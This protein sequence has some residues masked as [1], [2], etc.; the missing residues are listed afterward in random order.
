MPA[1][2]TDILRPDTRQAADHSAACFFA[3]AG[4]CRNLVSR[5]FGPAA[6]HGRRTIDVRHTDP[7][8]YPDSFTP[9]F[10]GL[11]FSID[12]S[13]QLG[14]VWRNGR[15]KT[16]PIRLLSGE[17]SGTGSILS[18]VGFDRF[19]F[20]C[21][22][23]QSALWNMRRAVAPFD[24]WEAEME[25]LLQEG[26]KASLARWGEIQE[27]YAAA[28]GYSINELPGKETARLWLDPDLLSR[29]LCSF[30]PGEQTR[31]QLAALFCK[32]NRFLL[33]DEHTNH[34]DMPGRKTVAAYLQGKQGFLLI[35]HDRA[36]LNTSVDHIAA[37][38]KTVM[39]IE[40][41]NYSSYRENKHLRDA[42]KLAQNERLEGEIRRLKQ[43]AREKTEW[44]D[45]VEAT[46]IG[47]GPTDCGRI[48]HWAAKAMKRSLSIRTR[49]D[50]EITEKEALLKDIEYASDLRLHPL[51]AQGKTCIRLV[52][53]DA[54]FPG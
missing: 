9:V 5:A 26:D 20:A 12:T 49:I 27:H 33:I 8:T 39:R 25:A 7:D 51:P 46:K 30:S 34:L 15:G 41:G 23:E 6:A 16:T 31:L 22:P 24:K 40:Q 21:E 35:S 13:W 10:I 37:P 42:F 14:L 28:N 19:P 45:K 36:F 47:N 52:P 38:E 11:S 17:L 53:V 48:G 18:G 54:C 32:K 2:G 4:A 1:F 43:T 3:P 44:S 29:P 50:R